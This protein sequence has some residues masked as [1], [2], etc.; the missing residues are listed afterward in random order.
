MCY[1]GL[2]NKKTQKISFCFK[3]FIYVQ[4]F[5]G[6]KIGVNQGKISTEAAIWRR[7]EIRCHENR[8]NFSQAKMDNRKRF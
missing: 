4:N 3:F 2:T 7:F 5:S 8:Q 6:T 1:Y